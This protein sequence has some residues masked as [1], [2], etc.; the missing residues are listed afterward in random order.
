MLNGLNTASDSP[1][2]QLLEFR[3]ASKYRDG[4][5]FETNNTIKVRE[6]CPNGMKMYL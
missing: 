5:S 3:N 2:D 6:V 1:I 4:H